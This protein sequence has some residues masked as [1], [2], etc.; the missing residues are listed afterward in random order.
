MLPCENGIQNFICSA[1]LK[2]LIH[3]L[4]VNNVKLEVM[5]GIYRLL[6]YF[7]RLLSHG[8]SVFHV[9]TWYIHTDFLHSDP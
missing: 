2:H 9:E 7:K 4:N 3:F 1:L 5:A 6:K 8:C